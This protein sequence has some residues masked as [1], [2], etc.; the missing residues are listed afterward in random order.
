MPIIDEDYPQTKESEHLMAGFSLGGYTVHLL[1][2]E[3]PGYFQHAAMYD[4]L[5]MWPEHRDPRIDSKKDAYTDRIWGRAHI[6]DPALGS[7]RDRT[8]MQR[9]NPTDMLDNA[10]PDMMDVLRTTTCWV[11]CAANDGNKGNLHRARFLL[12][13]LRAHDMPL[14]FS[15]TDAVFHPEAA[16]TGTGSTGLWCGFFEMRLAIGPTTQPRP[17]PCCSLKHRRVFNGP[18]A[19]QY[20]VIESA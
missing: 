15:D 14:G 12:K 8:A 16:H 7:P 18:A 4:G 20:E 13:R 9:W 3:R 10:S 11:A 2:M 6:F 1:A 17:I 5:F 19:V